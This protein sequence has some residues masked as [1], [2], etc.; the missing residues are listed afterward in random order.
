[1]V[2]GIEYYDSKKIMTHRE[3]LELAARNGLRVMESWEMHK[4]LVE[5]EDFRKSLAP[6]WYWCASVG[7]CGRY[8][9]WRF[10]GCNGYV[11]T[12]NRDYYNIVR[13]VAIV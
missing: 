7:Y 3:A 1:V 8:N 4:L 12:L 9:A 6:K 5:S 10:N 2:D 13:C 11:E